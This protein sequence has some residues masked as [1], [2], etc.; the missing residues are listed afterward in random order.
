MRS[1]QAGQPDGAAGVAALAAASAL[2]DGASP[3]S[4]PGAGTRRDTPGAR[5]A[6]SPSERS[7]NAA[8]TGER[9]LALKVDVD[10]LH[11]TLEGVPRLVE[12]LAARRLRATFLFS[13]GPDR[14]GVAL[15][16][17][18]RPGFLAK[19]GRTSVTSHYGLRTLLYGTL[20]PAPDIG[21]RAVAPM[22][23][24]R[25][26]GHEVGVHCWDHV[27]WQDRVTQR[28]AFWAGEQM[29]LAHA[30]FAE[31]FGTTPRVHGA[32]GW[33]M[34]DAAYRLEAELGFTHASDGRGRE[35][36][37]PVVDGVEVAVPQMPGTLPTLDE[38]IGTDG[39]DEHNVHAHLA[40]LTAAAR[41]RDQ[42]FTLHAELEGGKLRDAF[43]RMLDAWLAQGWSIGALD[44]MAAGLDVSR[45]PRCRVATGSVPGRSGTLA[46]QGEPVAA[47]RVR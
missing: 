8:L 37:V 12:V 18:F 47:R 15:R 3:A 26:A 36:F 23:A 5:A 44:A 45:L 30:R 41:G 31:V 9:R 35:P 42:V 6:A 14:T 38:L 19:V 25:D 28:A 43:E 16:R 21:R 32:A 17:I 34:S 10:T 27:E 39:L 11:G 22:R 29:R 4:G 13:V 2:S 46:V 40:A 24:A 33:Q 7:S 20:L 1:R